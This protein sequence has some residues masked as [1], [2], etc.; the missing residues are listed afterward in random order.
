MYTSG[1]DQYGLTIPAGKGILKFSFRTTATSTPMNLF[2][3][4]STSTNPNNF[5]RGTWADIHHTGTNTSIDTSNIG[6]FSNELRYSS[7]DEIVLVVDNQYDTNYYL[8]AA[9]TT[10]G[11]WI[12]PEYSYLI[13]NEDHYPS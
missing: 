11:T 1:N 3:G 6:S 7:S 2:F 12:Y 9:A 13:I 10:G 5:S 8:F 4:V